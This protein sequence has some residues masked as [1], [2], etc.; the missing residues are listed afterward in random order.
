MSVHLLCQAMT[1]SCA[2]RQDCVEQLLKNMFYEDQTE[3]CLVSG[4]Q[5]LLALLE[6]RRAG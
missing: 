1:S 3:S 2:H 5:V 6:P 4:T